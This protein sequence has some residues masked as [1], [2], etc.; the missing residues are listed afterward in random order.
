MSDSDPREKKSE[1]PS[2]QTQPKDTATKALEEAAPESSNRWTVLE[3][4]KKFLEDDEV[5]NASV[6]KR[7]AFLE[8][9]GLTSEEIQKILD[10]ARNRGATATPPSSVSSYSPN[11]CAHA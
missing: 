11:L 7:I 10:I 1:P 5:K 8:R 9:K 3:Q 2:W 6:D 4:A